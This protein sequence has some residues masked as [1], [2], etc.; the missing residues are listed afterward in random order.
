MDFFNKKM[1]KINL[2]D[3]KEAVVREARLLEIHPFLRYFHTVK[4][5]PHFYRGMVTPYDHRLFFVRSGSLRLRLERDGGITE[6]TIMASG[7]AFIPSGCS[8]G[9][10]E[11][12]GELDMVA[13]NFD[14]FF[15]HAQL[16]L[17]IP[18]DKREQF[19]TADLLER[20]CFSDAAALNGVLILSGQGGL[21]ET[22][23]QL[24]EE[25]ERQ[26]LYFREQQSVLLSQLLLRIARAAACGSDAGSRRTVEKVIALI[27]QEYDRPIDNA[28]IAAR[29]SYHPNYLNRLMQ[30]YTHCTLHQYLLNYRFDRALSLLMM[31]D[32]PLSE[33]ALRSGFADVSHFSK[34]FRKRMGQSP[35]KFR[36]NQ[37]EFKK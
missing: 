14:L 30:K 29:L 3:R 22:F 28:R 7:L 5:D 26:D 9:L 31:T 33:V 11:G 20:V 27:R 10:C 21:L 18:P 12:E 34:L 17:P 13:V 35:G 6:T 4:N 32:L 36:V 16:E 2:F 23:R 24:E 15:D 1:S 25:N 19:R 37:S 8:Y